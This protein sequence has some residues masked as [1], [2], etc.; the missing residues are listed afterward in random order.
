MW[1]TSRFVSPL[2]IIFSCIGQGLVDELKKALHDGMANGPR[3]EGDP[4]VIEVG[5]DESIPLF[6]DNDDL[7]DKV[8]HSN[9]SVR[10][11]L[12]VFRK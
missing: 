12:R 6:V 10:F 2:N 4:G 11:S 9:Y 7:N 1:V 5:S 8:C 3:L